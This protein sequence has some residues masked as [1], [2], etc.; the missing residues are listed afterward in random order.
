MAKTQPDWPNFDEVRERFKGTKY[1]VVSDDTTTRPIISAP[2][3]KTDREARIPRPEVLTRLLAQPLE[4]IVCIGDYGAI[5]SY[6]GGWIEAVVDS[7]Y[8]EPVYARYSI[9]FDSNPFSSDTKDPISVSKGSVAITIAAGT[10]SLWAFMPFFGD[11]NRMMIRPG[12]DRPIVSLRIEG[13][14]LA[15]NA[16]AVH[17]LERISSSLFFQIDLLRNAPLTLHRVTERVRSGRMFRRRE[18][19]L[20]DEVEFPSFEYDANALSYYWF[21]RSA[22]RSPQFQFLSFYQVLEYFFVPFAQ[23]EARARVKQVLGDPRFRPDRDVDLARLIGACNIQQAYSEREQLRLTIAALVTNDEIREFLDEDSDRRDFLTGAK[24]KRVSDLIIP[25]KDKNAD[26][27]LAL[28]NRIHD[29]RCQVVHTGAEH[30][31]DSGKLLLPTTERIRHL[32]F[33]IGVA[34]W[35]A[36]KALISSAAPLNIKEA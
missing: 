28:A 4:E 18:G 33:D 6:S 22:G 3:G 34:E 29:I 9:L 14:K 5:T 24:G 35:L 32:G 30:G 26:L 13:L 17:A 27:I 8:A 25:A 10:E 15:T 36:R 19:A 2:S 23:V 1:K 31:D 16:D 20:R 12:Q 7:V 21:A 11:L